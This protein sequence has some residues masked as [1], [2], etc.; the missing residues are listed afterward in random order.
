MVMRIVVGEDTEPIV[1]EQEQP[2]QPEQPRPPL[3]AALAVLEED[4]L[5]PHNILE[6]GSVSWNGLF[7]V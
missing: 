7:D 3:E 4:E 2:E 6:E 1:R 5:C